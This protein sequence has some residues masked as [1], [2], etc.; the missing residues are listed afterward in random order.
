ME[1]TSSGNRRRHSGGQ[2]LIFLIVMGTVFAVGTSAPAQAQ[3]R[4]GESSAELSAE[5][6]EATRAANQARQD[7]QRRAMSVLMGWS[8][9][10]M[11]V[12]TAGYFLSDGKTQY[13]H[14]MNAAWN[15]VNAAI[16]GAGWIGSR[17]E[18]PTALS[19]METVEADYRLQKILLLNMGLNLAYMAS[20]AYLWE[21]GIQRG[22]ERLE[23]YGPSLVLQGGFLLL[24]DSTFFLLQNRGARK[25]RQHLSLTWADGP[26]VGLQG[27]F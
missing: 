2:A 8:V 9:L 26:M 19:P 6:A 3:E 4:A 20:G 18:D 11:G 25:F 24:F 10:N 15:V 27:R 17:G 5:L 7:R 23:G 12:G 13:F 22:D 16:A 21:R 1:H 14:Q